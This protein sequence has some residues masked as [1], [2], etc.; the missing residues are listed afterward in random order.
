[1]QF[2]FPQYIDI[3]DKIFGPLTLKQFI[4]VVG[5][6]GASFVFWSLLPKYLSFIFIFPII[7]VSF[8]LAFKPVQGRPFIIILEAAFRYLF[9]N[10]LY[11]WRK[12]RGKDVKTV[13]TTLE[14]SADNEPMPHIPKV[15]EGKLDDMA[16]SLDVQKTIGR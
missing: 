5:G 15:L 11:L 12:E 7:I 14:K 2:H 3:E 9:G 16:L 13:K 1:M 4:Y 10:K 6:A 8:L